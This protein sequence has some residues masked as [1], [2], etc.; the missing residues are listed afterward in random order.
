MLLLSFLSS[1]HPSST[2]LRPKPPVCS[3]SAGPLRIQEAKFNCSKKTFFRRY[4]QSKYRNTEA[5]PKPSVKGRQSK[6][7]RSAMISH[8][9]LVE[10]MLPEQKGIHVVENPCPASTMNLHCHTMS[11]LLDRSRKHKIAEIIWIWWIK[12]AS[13]YNSLLSDLYTQHIVISYQ[14]GSYDSCSCM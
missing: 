4:S 12:P 8:V 3:P 6:L 11:D 9:C 1:L 14:L 13:T 2:L 5:E 7:Y 10:S